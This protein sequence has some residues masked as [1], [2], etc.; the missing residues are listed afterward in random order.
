MTLRIGLFL[1]LLA[2]LGAGGFLWWTHDGAKPPAYQLAKVQRGDV[3]AAV[4]ATGKLTPLVVVQVGSQVSGQVKEIYVDYNSPVKKGQL[5]ALIDP[6][7]YAL[8]VDQALGDLST[9][10][11]NVLT[12]RAQLA[13][14]RADVARH[15]VNLA[16]AERE[17]KRSQM[18]YEQ[19]F[20][21]VGVRDKAEAALAAAREQLNAA[22]AQLAVGVLQVES[23]EALVK[24]RA[25]QVAQA[26]VELERTRIL[27]PVDG[28]VVQK[29]VEPGQTVA[30]SLQ[31]PDLFL[32][33][34]DLTK[35]Q[36]LASI[37]EAEVGRVKVGQRAS[38]T[39]DAFPGRSFRGTVRQ[40]RKSAVT[41]QNVVTYTAAVETA[42][43]DL[44]LYPGMT[45]NMRIIVDNRENVLKI[46]NAALR[47]R[48][49]QGRPESVKTVA[50]KGALLANLSTVADAGR[51]PAGGTN[52][53]VWVL[54]KDGQPQPVAIRVGLTD[55]NHGELVDGNLDEGVEVII[56]TA[57]TAPGSTKA[58][59]APGF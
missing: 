5:I 18:L 24:Q 11:A 29:S 32:I 35:M 46:P 54:G 36:V 2:G 34:Q 21:S 53:R 33:A 8:R 40:I 23:G 56:G 41:M 58:K 20:L 9:A 1:V 19:K 31:A 12:Q 38:F 10:Q 22:E 14:L 30:A 37:D 52:A 7:F 43:A 25:S 50:E 3:T 4:T 55:G 6:A 26:R 49:A 16:D 57:G 44:T 27:A 17:Y 39:V 42:N 47:F 15:K 59:R 13:V 28:I 48:P 51:P 45:A